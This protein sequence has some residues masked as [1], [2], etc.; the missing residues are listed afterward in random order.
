MAI[1]HVVDNDNVINSII[2]DSKEFVE[3][4]YPGLAVV[5]DDGV[6]GVGWSKQTGDWIAPYPT[7][8][9][10]YIWNETDKFWELVLSPEE[11]S[12]VE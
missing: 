5:E 6:I 7:D 3:S 4:L 1:W 2:A 10:E 9:N 12:I 8:G 11:E